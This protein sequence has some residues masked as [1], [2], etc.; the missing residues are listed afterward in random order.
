MELRRY[1]VSLPPPIPSLIPPLAQDAKFQNELVTKQSPGS[2]DDGNI[3]IKGYQDNS[4]RLGE[5]THACLH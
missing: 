3:V 5:A 2:R 1:V 4:N